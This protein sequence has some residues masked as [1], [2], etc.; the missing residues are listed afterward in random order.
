MGWSGEG[1]RLIREEQI[2]QFEAAGI[3]WVE[4]QNYT[5]FVCLK[6]Q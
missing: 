2:A 3:L 1:R 4:L 5:V 6:I